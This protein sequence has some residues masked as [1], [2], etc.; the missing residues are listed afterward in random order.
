MYISEDEHSDKNRKVKSPALFRKHRRTHNIKANTAEDIA[1]AT[2]ISMI[3]FF[4]AKITGFLREVLVAPKLGFGMYSDPY[5]VAFFIPDFLYALLIGGAVA[6]AITPTLS[7]GIENNQEKRVWK[8][9]STFITLASATMIVVLLLV[10]L[11]MP[12]LLPAVNPGKAEE[13][14]QAAI[15]VSRILLLQCVFM[16]LISLTQGVLNAY[17]RFGLAAF[18]VM[19][20]NILYMI[21]LLTLG[22]QS[23]KGLRNVAWGVVG[24]AFAYFLYQLVLSRHEIRYFHLSFD[25]RDPGFK[26]LLL[27][28]IPTLISGSVLHL[29][30]LIMNWF[31]NQFVGAATAIR[32]AEQ[33]FMLPYGIVAVAIG[34]VMLPNMTGFYAKRDFKKV[35]V[36]FTK[37]IRKAIFYIAPIAA[38][39]YVLSFETIQLIFQWNAQEYTMEDVAIVGNILRWFCVSLIAQTVIYMTN[40]AFYARKV[41]KT[42]LFYGIVTLIL[43][44]IFCILYTKVFDFGINGIAMAHASYSIIGAL[45]IYTLYKIHN[46][47]AKPYRILPFLIKIA[48]CVIVTVVVLS[49]LN[50]FSSYTTSKLLQIMLYL[51]KGSVGIV[52]FYI[53]GI[54][55]NLKETR[56]LQAMILGK[57][58]RSKIQQTRR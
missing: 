7:G 29:N 24:S 14:I 30:S 53:A 33:A 9:V 37:S 3:G 4:M 41:T 56:D 26:R 21:V 19:I 11:I 47:K 54:S 6:A 43:N 49:A 17:K 2:I 15:P 5:Y 27:L 58:G 23:E 57:F 22:E 55:I 20:Y 51:I 32:H 25:Y 45:I 18:G 10:G 52:V 38:I 40:Q 34:T 39:F 35:R 28:A 31:T 36:L 44:P 16:T 42:A 12:W 1:K 8:S 48:Y 13:V 46:P 50:V